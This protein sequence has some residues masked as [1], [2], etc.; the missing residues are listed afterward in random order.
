MFQMK[1]MWVYSQSSEET[2]GTGGQTGSPTLQPSSITFYWSG[3]CE[4]AAEKQG[5]N[6]KVRGSEGDW[7]VWQRIK[8]KGHYTYM[9]IPL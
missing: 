3:R 8:F 7:T 1:R 6:R 9:K 4:T 5:T 2:R